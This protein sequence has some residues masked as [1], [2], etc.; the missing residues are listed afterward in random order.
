MAPVFYG[1]SFCIHDRKICGNLR[2]SGPWIRRMSYFGKWRCVFGWMVLDVAKRG[3]VFTLK[4]QK[5]VLDLWPSPLKVLRFFNKAWAT[6]L[7]TQCHNPENIYPSK[8]TLIWYNP[9]R[10]RAQQIICTVMRT[11]M[12]HAI[13]FTW[14]FLYPEGKEL[15]IG[16]IRLAIIGL[17]LWWLQFQAPDNCLDIL[18]S[19]T[20]VA[21]EAVERRVL[22]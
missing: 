10:R 8:N 17:L 20:R 16:L 19:F 12:S 7:K 11:Q 15:V 6:Y 18:Y 2:L 5:V 4:G 1:N 9:T 21:F 22:P 13:S 3:G 14:N